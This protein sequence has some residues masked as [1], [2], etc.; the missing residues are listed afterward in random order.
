MFNTT[1]N[2]KLTEYQ[3]ILGSN[4]PRRREIL[5]NNLG[6]KEFVVIGS[7]FA[8]DLEKSDKTPLEYVQ[9]TSKHK[10]E[11]LLEV[12]KEK[13]SNKDAIILTCD[14]IVTANGRIFEKPK[15]KHEQRN[16]FEFYK[17]HPDLEVISAITTIKIKKDNIS[18]YFDHSITK[19][20]FKP[21]NDEVMTAYIE[22][23]EGL[24]VAGG[25]KYQELGCLLFSEISGDY[26]NVVG[27]PTS[28]FELLNRTVTES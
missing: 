1:L 25:F 3:L 8:E 19:L 6:I 16:Y 2:K 18:E 23:E 21:N 5:K 4:S 11:A 7:D 13:F 26:Y 9:L 12:Y 22:S 28:T 27:L 17:K 14:T 20:K 24:E 10:A 15:S